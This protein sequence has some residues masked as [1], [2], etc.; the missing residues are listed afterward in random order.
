MGLKLSTAGYEGKTTMLLLLLLLFKA[1]V[2]RKVIPL[3]LKNLGKPS[4]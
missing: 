4:Y 3:P 2:I 1:V